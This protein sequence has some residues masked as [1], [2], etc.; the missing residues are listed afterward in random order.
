MDFFAKML[1]MA[2]NP[3]LIALGERLRDLRVA[4]GKGLGRR[5]TM[6]EVADALGIKYSRY[7]AY[8][9]GRAELPES[10]AKKLA[11]IWDIPWQLFYRDGTYNALL[12]V[13]EPKTRHYQGREGLREVSLAG[14]PLAPIPIVGEIRPDRPMRYIDAGTKQLLVPK[15]MAGEDRLGYVAPEHSHYPFEEDDGL[16]F[17]N[18]KRSPRRGQHFLVQTPL[19]KLVRRFEWREGAWVMEQAGE[20]PET[21]DAASCSILGMFVGL[22]RVK[23]TKETILHDPEGLSL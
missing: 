3:R 19:D 5:Y 12:S 9:E 10:L 6:V 4:H 14:T 18:L 7:Q 15:H 13:S 21:F 17:T 16:I 22:Y 1:L 8:E 20:E 23:G 2:K 11:D